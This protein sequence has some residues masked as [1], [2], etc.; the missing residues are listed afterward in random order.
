MVFLCKG[1]S[2]RLVK[3]YLRQNDRSTFWIEDGNKFSSPFD[4]MLILSCT[5]L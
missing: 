2:Y 4:I 5:A 1:E 3:I